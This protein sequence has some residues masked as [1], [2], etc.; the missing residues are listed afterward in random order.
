[1]TC[2]HTTSRRTT[3]TRLL[4]VVATSV[5]A[6]AVM[7]AAPMSAS[8][9]TTY[10]TRISVP[11]GPSINV[12]TL[13]FASKRTKAPVFSARAAAVGRLPS[14]V[15]FLSGAKKNPA[16]GRWVGLLTTIRWST[17]K[18]RAAGAT[19]GLAVRADLPFTVGIKT[20]ASGRTQ[21]GRMFAGGGYTM[22]AGRTAAGTLGDQFGTP[23]ALLANI[24]NIIAGIGDGQLMGAARDQ[25]AQQPGQVLLR[26]VP[27]ATGTGTGRIYDQSGTINCRLVAGAVT[28]DCSEP[29]FPNT[30][31]LMVH[32]AES[33][34]GF[35]TWQN[36]CAGKN[37]NFGCSFPMPAV[38]TD[39]SGFF[40]KF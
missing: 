1:M 21:A 29:A 25:V 10:T 14:D 27:F 19:A 33:G 16:T 37:P 24:G 38:A 3:G 23:R 11:A 35:E 6:L 39:V 40:V 7:T 4:A 18:P 2:I 17:G 9:G 28:G 12:A 30:N 15:T 36:H 8:A 5:A 22:R 34:S 13:H 32:A 31:I 20:R 26:V